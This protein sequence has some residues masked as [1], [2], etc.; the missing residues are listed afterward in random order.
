VWICADDRGHLQAVGTDDAGRRQYRYHDAWRDQ[1]DREKFAHI[2]RFAERLPDV[3]AQVTRDLRRRGFP[4]ERVLACSVRLLERG[5]FRIG[6]EDYAEANGSFGLAT[7]RKEHVTVHKVSAE[8]DFVGKAGKRHVRE[9]SDPTV[10]PIIRALRRRHD[11]EELLAFREGDAWR[12]VRSADINTYVKEIAGDD[13]SAKDFRT[14]HATVL[15][16]VDLAGRTPVSSSD[17]ARRGAVS[18]TVRHVAGHLGNTPAVCRRSYIDPRVFDR[19]LDDDVTLD[20]KALA[21][22]APQEVIEEAVLALLRGGS[23]SLALAA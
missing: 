10:I 13:F 15:A 4:R 19:Y 3:R 1:R 12:D 7:L 16:A 14:W 11:G 22:G 8:F 23:G 20:L 5:L 18:K 21:E 6:S 2:E 17:R 9:V